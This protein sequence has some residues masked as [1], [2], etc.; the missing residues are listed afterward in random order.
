MARALG[1]ELEVLPGNRAPWHP[2]RC[3]QVLV[4]GSLAGHAGELH[5][6]VCKSFGVP[7]RTS[8][9]ELDLDLMM[10]LASDVVPAPRFSTF[11]VAKEDVSLVVDAAVAAADVEDALRH[12]AGDLLESARLFDVYVGEQVG[13]GKK[14]LAYSLRF[15]APDRTLTEKEVRVAVEAAV[16]AASDRVSAV[17]RV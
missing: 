17:Q 6:G 3:A 16:A 15:R 8:A 2:G 13:T 4:G 11:P 10:Q 12:G 9:A 1:L 7:A 14:S 5:P